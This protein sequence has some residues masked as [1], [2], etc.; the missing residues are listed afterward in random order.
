MMYF[1][2]LYYYYFSVVDV[3][4]MVAQWAKPKKTNLC[5][6]NSFNYPI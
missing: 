2:L 5:N 4:N 3:E 6:T 1:I